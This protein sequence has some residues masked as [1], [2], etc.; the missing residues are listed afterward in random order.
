MLE[1]KV[2][3]KYQ[4]DKKGLRRCGN[5][6][7]SVILEPPYECHEFR[8]GRSAKV[9]QQLFCIDCSQKLEEAGEEDV[10]VELA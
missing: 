3:R 7:C 5:L 8:I 9:Y 1:I 4:R 10:M 2:R 6:Y